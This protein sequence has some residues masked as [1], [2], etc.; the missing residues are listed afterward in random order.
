MADQEQ[1]AN[2][3]E[4]VENCTYGVSIVRMDDFSKGLDGLNFFSKNTMLPNVIGVEI[5]DSLAQYFKIGK[6]LLHDQ[7][8]LLE[9]LPFTGNE[10]IAVRYK[11]KA[12]DENSGEKIVYFRIYDIQFTDNPRTA[13]A[14]PGSKFITIHLVEFPAFDMFSTATIYKSFKNNE[15]TIS[16]AVYSC[17]TGIKNIDKYYNIDKPEPTKGKINFWIPHWSLVK[18][19]KYVQPY[20][21]NELNEP[22]YIFSIKQDDM[23]TH[24]NSMKHPTIHYHSIF[25]NLK[26]KAVRTF[27]SQR[28]EQKLR[29]SYG[30]VDDEAKNKPSPSAEDDKNNSPPDV[31]LGKVQKSF[32]GSMLLFGMN[33][34]T[35]I[36][37]DA[38]EGTSYFAT[39]FESFLQEYSGLGMW[40]AYQKEAGTKLWGNQWSAVSNSHLSPSSFKSNL[41]QNYFRNL[42]SKRMMLGSSRILVYSYVNELR[43][44]GEKVNL[45]LP[46]SDKEIGIDMMNS[47][48]WVIWSITDKIT[49]S[50]KAVSEIELV[51]DS[52]F[53]IPND[54][55]NNFI[56][57]IKTLSSS[58]T[59]KE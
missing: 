46:S 28:A 8:Q 19:L 54:R 56:P 58:N 25:K 27:S 18:T 35:I 29:D 23:S 4:M 44:T 2:I 15:T 24:S 48:D 30:G 21:V 14:N 11:N 38:I 37:R 10:V 5:T 7:T 16:D 49:S 31:I 57:R 33:G 50:G 43:S 45:K 12:N 22:L 36:G 13:N 34:E 55:I 42:Y 41:V 1:R 51:R 39:T 32:D 9:T 3:T 20:A 52:Y 47:G 6:I 53:L 17:L 59:A 40:S 26:G